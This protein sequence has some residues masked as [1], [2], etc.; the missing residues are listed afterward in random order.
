MS[1]AGRRVPGLLA[2]GAVLVAASAMTAHLAGGGPPA[3]SPEA[4]GS[5]DVETAGSAD[6]ETAVFAL[7]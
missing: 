4:A 3:P 7:G 1:P 6:V 5:A 2:A